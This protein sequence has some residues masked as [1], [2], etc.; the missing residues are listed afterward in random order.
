MLAA[1]KSVNLTCA[2]VSIFSLE[3]AM[4]S[5]FGGDAQF[6]LLMTSATAAA[7]CIL[8]LLIAIFLVASVSRKLRELS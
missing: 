1:A 5:Q 2:L 6:Q 8:V 3:T 7:V 4:L